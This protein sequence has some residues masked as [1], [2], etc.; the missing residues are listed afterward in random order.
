[1]RLKIEQLLYG[2]LEARQALNMVNAVRLRCQYP[3]KSTLGLLRIASATTRS[4]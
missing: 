2:I 4:T 3:Q 1:M